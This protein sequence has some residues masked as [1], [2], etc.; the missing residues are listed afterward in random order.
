MIL[1]A[2][3]TQFIRLQL[4]ELLSRFTVAE[5]VCLLA[6]NEWYK[7]TKEIQRIGIALACTIE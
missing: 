6:V 2:L 5:Q 7:I 1:G 4:S 3:Q